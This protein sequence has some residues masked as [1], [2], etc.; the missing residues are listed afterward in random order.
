MFINGHSVI[1]IRHTVTWTI[2]QTG[3]CE[4]ALLKQKQ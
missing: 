2:D 3:L 4:L 1:V